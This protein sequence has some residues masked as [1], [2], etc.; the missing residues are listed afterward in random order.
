MLCLLG[1]CKKGVTF[2]SGAMVRIQAK[3]WR[4]DNLMRD[5]IIL[6]GEITMMV[7]KRTTVC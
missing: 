4:D 5:W 7:E 2:P 6:C 3:G 1:H